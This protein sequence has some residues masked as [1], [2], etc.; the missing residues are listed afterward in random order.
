LDY[1][2]PRYATGIGIDQ[3]LHRIMVSIAGTG[4]GAT[5][6][7]LSFDLDATGNALPVRDLSGAGLSPGWV[8]SPTAMPV[9]TLFAN[10]FEQ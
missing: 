6:R 4:D 7:V 1:D 5:N 10:G 8:G 9:D 3:P 2:S